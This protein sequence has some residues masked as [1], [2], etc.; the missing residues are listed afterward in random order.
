[1]IVSDSGMGFLDAPA[2]F[3][4]V[5]LAIAIGLFELTQDLVRARLKAFSAM[6]ATLVRAAGLLGLGVLAALSG[7][8][9]FTLLLAA[10][11]AYL[12][13]VLAQSRTAWRGTHF[14]F[15]RAALADLARTG[16]PLTISRTSS[17]LS[18]PCSRSRLP[19]AAIVS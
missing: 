12:F 8:T 10:A 7:P 6:K 16:L 4:A 1:M 11:L 18:S 9:G 14:R 2:A 19:T 3:A 5:G 13:A 17:P 15:D